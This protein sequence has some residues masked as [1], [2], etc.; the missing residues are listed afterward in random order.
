M[1]SKSSCLTP[2]APTEILQKN[3]EVVLRG[4]REREPAYRRLAGLRC[5]IRSETPAGPGG[6]TQAAQCQRARISF[7]LLVILKSEGK[8]HDCFIKLST[9]I[10]CFHMKSAI[11]QVEKKYFNCRAA[12]NEQRT[13]AGGLAEVLM[14]ETDSTVIQWLLRLPS[15][16]SSLLETLCVNRWEQMQPSEADQYT[17]PMYKD[18]TGGESKP[19][20]GQWRKLI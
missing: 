12:G 16:L 20:R 19:C 8:R 14:N 11:T 1:F 3:R 5:Y 15:S 2:L 18:S 9:C 6:E 4:G 7:T 13:S 17:G 10:S